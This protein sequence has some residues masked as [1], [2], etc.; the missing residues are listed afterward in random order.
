M[1]DLVEELEGLKKRVVDARENKAQAEGRKDEILR[2]L[3]DDHGIKSAE[4]GLKKLEK[5][6]KEEEKLT[7][8]LES[9]LGEIEEKLDGM[10][11]GT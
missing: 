8:V 9:A 4:D 5:L 1:S 11:A 6:K 2:R 10:E 7:V 3:K